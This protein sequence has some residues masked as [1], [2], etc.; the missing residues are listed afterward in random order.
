MSKLTPY[1]LKYIFKFLVNFV[2]EFRSNGYIHGD[3]KP[4]NVMICEENE[5]LF[6]K[7]IDMGTVTDSIMV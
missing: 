1:N 3:I 2:L 5:I 6:L 4:D 7:I